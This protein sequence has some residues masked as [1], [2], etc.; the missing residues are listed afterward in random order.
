MPFVRVSPVLPLSYGNG[1]QP[2]LLLVSVSD[3]LRV[4][5]DKSEFSLA[6]CEITW[7]PLKDACG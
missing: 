5:S 1:P 3:P 6:L 4:L 2:L 7:R